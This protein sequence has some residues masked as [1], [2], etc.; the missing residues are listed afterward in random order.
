MVSVCLPSDASRNTI[1]LGFLLPWKWGISSRLL[2]QSAATAPYFGRG[3]SPHHS[4]SWPWIWDRSSRPFC[5]HSA[6]ADWLFFIF[7]RFLLKISCVFSMSLVYLSETPFCFQDFE[8]FL[9]SLFWILFQVD[10]QSPPLLF[11]MVGIYHVPLPAEY[12]SAFSFCS[13][14]CVWGG[15]SVGCKFVGPLYCGACSLW[16][17]LD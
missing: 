4:P 15:L 1:L 9:L 5:I 6:T 8:S 17:G 14:F 16:V 11:G 13:D 7:S 2:Q 10:S 12:F 3:V